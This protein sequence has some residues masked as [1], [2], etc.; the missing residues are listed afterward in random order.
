MYGGHG[1]SRCPAKLELDMGGGRH[2]RRW[3][4]SADEAQDRSPRSEEPSP[5]RDGAPMEDFTKKGNLVGVLGFSL[6]RVT[7]GLKE[8]QVEAELGEPRGSLAS[9]DD[10][11]TI[12]NCDVQIHPGG[13]W[14]RICPCLWVPT[15]ASR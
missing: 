12:V 13:S 2:W 11:V 5:S 10:L 14:S 6:G 15:L 3:G 8:R 9:D 4:A 7:L 1:N